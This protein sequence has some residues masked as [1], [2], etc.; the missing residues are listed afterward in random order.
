[1][2]AQPESPAEEITRLRGCLSDLVRITALPVLS[3]GGGLSRVASTLLDTLVGTLLLSF[4][5]VRLN[6]PEGGP[7]FEMTRVAEPFEDTA[8]AGEIGEALKEWL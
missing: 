6:D 5:F 7:S 8:C 4:A 1:M 3:T 2:R